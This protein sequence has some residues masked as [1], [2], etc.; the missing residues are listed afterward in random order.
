MSRTA[1]LRLTLVMA[2][3]SL[4]AIP[5]A[6]LSLTSWIRRSGLED[7]AFLAQGTTVLEV[8]SGK[9]ISKF[10]LGLVLLGG[11]G[12]LLVARR[13]RPAGMMA[14]FVA[15]VQLGSTLAAG[16][17][18]TPFGRLRPSETLAGADTVD[19]WFAGGSSFPSGHVAFYFGLFLPLAYL[20]PRWR[21][22][23]LL[24]P[25]FI[26]VAR[27]DANDHY[28][29]DVA[30]SVALAAAITVGAAAAMRHRLPAMLVLLFAGLGTNLAA[31]SAPARP[32]RAE[33][34]Q[35]DRTR[36]AEAFRL[37]DA[38]SD[39]VWAG[40]SQAPFA[41][42]LVTETQEFLLRHPNP[43]ADFTRVGYDS[44]L[45]TDVFVRPR[46]FAPNLLATFPAVGGVPTIVI[47]R[48]EATN[49]TSAAWVLTVLHEHFHQLQSSRPDYYPGVAALGL[50]RGDQ[51]G[52]WMLNY[53]FPYDS[54]AV[55]ARF[56]A[57]A[58]ALHA[59]LSAPA[60]AAPADLRRSVGDARRALRQA[61][62]ADDDKYLMFQM[63]QEGVARYTELRVA[64]AAARGG[65]PAAAFRALPD[66]TAYA[67]EARQLEQGI[68]GGI[69]D[70]K[71]GT[72]RRTAVYPL[73]AATALLFDVIAPEWQRQYFDWRFV[74]DAPLR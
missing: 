48:A 31:Q 6:D 74:L 68:L 1:L 30:A 63:W 32:P 34:P 2:A 70:V 39:S 7:G 11:S 42:L 10:L 56:G 14:L 26:A 58:G 20:Y 35:P 17:A 60:S 24:V 3:V 41:V 65:A 49:K 54:A 46:V 8:V 72:S 15:L 64:R 21:W 18:K 27:I 28:L 36:L 67:D 22:P 61:L 50:A 62:A 19:R 5:F 52:M 55:Q 71:L 38:V 12:A 43:S 16:V 4:L 25:C 23:L 53:P 9:T 37:A 44:L 69:R 33:L 51:T 59:A 45:R 29:S 73:G 47:G 40:W 13:T 57:Y 66:Y